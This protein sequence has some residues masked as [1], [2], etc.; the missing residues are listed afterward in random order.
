MK[1]IYTV[2]L[3]SVIAIT[4]FGQKDCDF[5]NNNILKGGDTSVSSQIVDVAI[6][7]FSSST[8]ITISFEYIKYNS[9]FYLDLHY[10]AV[11]R[12][13][14]KIDSGS[15][16]VITLQNDSTII[17]FAR[18]SAKS[19][20]TSSRYSYDPGTKSYDG[21]ESTTTLLVRY[22]INREQLELIRDLKLKKVQMFAYPSWYSIM[23]EATQRKRKVK[24]HQEA[25]EC[26]L[27]HTAADIKK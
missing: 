24:K 1:K 8:S 22:K 16:L 26:M 27:N 4:S 6:S 17:L 9:D 23:I 21:G 19:Q 5:A 18:D 15:K 2:F 12:N 3:L 13:E 11:G 20:T 7:S 14:L 25:I 10:T